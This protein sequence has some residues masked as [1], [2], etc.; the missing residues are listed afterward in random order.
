MQTT[1]YPL[2]PPSLEELAD[3]LQAPLAA[4]YEHSSVSIVQC[5]DLRQAPFHLASEGLSGNEKI[6][7]IGGQGHLFPRP[8]LDR[9]YTMDKIA[10]AMD[11]SP[12]KGS[13][14]GAGAGPF[15]R[16]GRNCELS[17]NISWKQGYENVDNKTC[18]AQISPNTGDVSIKKSP[19]LECAL[20][21]NLYGSESEPGPVIKITA[22]KRRGQERSFTECIRK[23][24][25]AAFG[26]LKTISLGGAFLIKTGKARYHV[27]PDFPPDNEL[28]FKDSRQL[29]DWLTYHDFDGPIVCMT[30]LHSSDPGKAMGLRMEHTHGYSPQGGDCGGHYH[31]DVDGDENIEY[32]GYFNTAKAIYRIDMPSVRLERDLH[33]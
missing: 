20:M 17:P 21:A 18:F 13:L 3:N 24:L 10:E 14:I 11:M 29:N 32:E 33:D 2:S 7:D 1:K 22:R 4:N 23:A 12:S 28:P 6:A 26:D 19:S 15:H 8:L 5:P 9:I 30:V 25:V 27:M 16:V 31:Y